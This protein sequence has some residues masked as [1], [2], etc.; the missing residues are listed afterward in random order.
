[1]A[2]TIRINLLAKELGVP[3][4]TIIDKCLA[5]GVPAEAVKNHQSSVPVGLAASIREWFSSGG[6]TATA[7]EATEH[8]D[9][10]MVKAKASPKMRKGKA[11]SDDGPSTGLDVAVSEPAEPAVSTHTTDEPLAPTA[12]AMPVVVP[13][14]AIPTPRPAATLAPAPEVS[15]APAPPV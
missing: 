3:S 15:E 10:A 4:K 14:P 12:R 2:T 1:M 7:V 13:A 8:L 11:G 9:V 6:G 5:E